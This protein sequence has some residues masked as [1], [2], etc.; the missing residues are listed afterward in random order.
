MKDLVYNSTI[1]GNIFV[2]GK[3][4]SGKTTLIQKYLYKG[5]FGDLVKVFWVSPEK[6]GDSR[7]GERRKNSS[8]EISFLYANSPKELPGRY[9]KAS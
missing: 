3:T 1:S 5:F 6:L 9:I 8:Y 4:G 7:K 2:L